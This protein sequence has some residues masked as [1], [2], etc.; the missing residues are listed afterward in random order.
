MG[1]MV[2]TTMAMLLAK[3]TTTLAPTVVTVGSF[4]ATGAMVVME[5]MPLVVSLFTL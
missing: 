4:L 2:V 3:G 1:V 5:A